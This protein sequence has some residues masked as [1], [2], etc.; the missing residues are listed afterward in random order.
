MAGTEGNVEMNAGN[1]N[2]PDKATR[3][4]ATTIAWP[5]LTLAI[6][7]RVQTTEMMA[8]SEFSTEWAMAI[9][10]SLERDVADT[11]EDEVKNRPV[12]K[13]LKVKR[14][15]DMLKTKISR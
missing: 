5:K 2:V 4:L 14:S 9:A 7:S 11:E 8:R 6:I 12:D 10:I 1:L 13:L 3:E 15:W